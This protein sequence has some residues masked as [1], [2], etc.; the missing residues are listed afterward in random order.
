[1]HKRKRL[2]NCMDPG[3]NLIKPMVIDAHVQ[4]CTARL[5]SL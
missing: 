2:R 4:L 5:A 3:Y 1:M